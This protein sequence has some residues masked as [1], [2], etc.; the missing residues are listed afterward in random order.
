M[1]VAFDS[2]PVPISSQPDSYFN[3][4]ATPY[5]TA[6]PQEGESPTTVGTG[7]TPYFTAPVSPMTH[8]DFFNAIQSR[9]SSVTFNTPAIST[10]STPVPQT[11]W[12]HPSSVATTLSATG[13]AGRRKSPLA[14]IPLP[15]PAFPPPQTAVNNGP[16]AVPFSGPARLLPFTPDQLARLLTTQ[17]C[18]PLDFGVALNSNP[19]VVQSLPNLKRPA[20]FTQP[21]LVLDMRS[22]VHYSHGR[23]K[24]SVN[25]CIPNTILRRGT[26]TLDKVYEAI[27][28]E[29]DRSRLRKW[30]TFANIVLYDNNSEMMQDGCAIVYLCQKLQQEKYNGS[31]GYLKGKFCSTYYHCFGREI[32]YM[33]DSIRCL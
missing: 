14:T 25:V 19:S 2:P 27:V 1:S 15:P 18:V 12:N 22:F 28:S 33:R 21:V 6:T 30:D 23:V 5:N 9:H 13:L 3:P 26:F 20:H 31:L 29:G 24:S 8:Q 10:P 17:S 16:P 11:P 7:E 4:R 32:A